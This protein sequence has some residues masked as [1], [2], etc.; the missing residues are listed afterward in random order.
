MSFQPSSSYVSDQMLLE[1]AVKLKKESKLDLATTRMALNQFMSCTS[2]KVKGEYTNVKD[3]SS[4]NYFENLRTSQFESLTQASETADKSIELCRNKLENSVEINQNKIES[5]RKEIETLEREIEI[6][7][8][9]SETKINKIHSDFRA[10]CEK[11]KSTIKFCD[12]SMDKLTINT[13]QKKELNNII[14]QV[15]E[16]ILANTAAALKTDKAKKILANITVAPVTA[17][18]AA[19]VFLTSLPPDIDFAAKRI[20]DKADLE[21][22]RKAQQEQ[23]DHINKIIEKQQFDIFYEDQLLCLKNDAKWEGKEN[24][25]EY[26]TACRKRTEEH[27]LKGYISED[28]EDSEDCEDD[29]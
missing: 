24:T 3:R 16:T 10:E 9:K 15:K 23:T 26:K 12:D 11:R 18:V 5:K 20:Q 28:Y 25:L 21:D 8:K 22:F 19:P 2:A 14:V 1:N 7:E 6:L 4:Y 27:I 17:P 13:E 29:D